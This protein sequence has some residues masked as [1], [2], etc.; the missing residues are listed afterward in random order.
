MLKREKLTGKSGP[1]WVMLGFLLTLSL[2]GSCSKEDTKE[3]V[4]IPDIALNKSELTLEKGKTERLIASFTPAET[5]DKGH[6]WTSST[7]GVAMVDETGM[8]T[9]VKPGEAVVT[10]TAL[11][12]KKTAT[13]K[14][15]VVDKIVRVAG[16]S[17]KPTVATMVVG[18]DLALEATV[19]PENATNKVVAWSSSDSKMASVDATGKVTAIAEGKI[20]I[21]ATTDDGDKTASCQITIVH[22]GVEISKPEVSDIT[23][24]SALVE[25]TVK[26]SG[27][28]VTEVGICYSTSQSPTVNDKKVVL[29]GEDISYTLT[30]LEANTTYYVRIYAVVD[31]AAKYGD[32]AMFTTEVAVEISVP[33][34][35]SISSSSAQ[36]SGTITTYGLQMEEAGICYSTSSMPTVDATKVVLSGN[37]IAYTLNELTPETVY[38]VRIYA[39]L[40]GKYY[41][42]DQGT[43]TTSGIIKTHFE[44]TDIYEDRVMLTSAAPSGVT[45]VDVCYGTS[46]NPKI[47]DNITTASVGNDGKLNLSL[48]GLSKGTTY[49]LRAYSRVGSKIEYYDDEV[50][51][52]TVGGE[53][54]FVKVNITHLDGYL[55]LWVVCVINIDGTYLVEIDGDESAVFKKD[56]DYVKSLYIEDGTSTF[57]YRQKP[58]DI[59]NGYYYMS[60]ATLV[61]TNIDSGVRYYYTIPY[62]RVNVFDYI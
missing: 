58:N 7:P 21:K 29:S 5:P 52:Q 25:G 30:K 24:I 37:E 2:A 27:V 4:V 35:S 28:K 48:T 22:R 59:G 42:G 57:N 26:P 17:I 13:C 31:G 1:V 55:N 43:F 6:V 23:S 36:V 56:V 20:T 8:V 44:A 33:Q 62:R 53:E 10:A 39:K 51:V 49:Y 14:V 15:T 3:E 34:I 32:Q 45:K 38:Y 60:Q 18:D 47:T 50:S 12:G 16:V 61:F 19:A 41:Y 54:F 46:P 9:A 11:T 40:D